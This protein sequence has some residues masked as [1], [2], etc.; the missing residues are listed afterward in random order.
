MPSEEVHD[1]AIQQNVAKP[2]AA[3]AAHCAAIGGFIS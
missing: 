1:R 2:D 3:H